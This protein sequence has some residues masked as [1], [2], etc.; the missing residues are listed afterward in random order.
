MRILA[1]YRHYWPDTPPYARI[2]RSILEHLAAGDHETTVYA[3]Q[4]SYNDIRQPPQPWRENVGGVEIRRIRLL[5]ERKQ[6]RLA[7]AI[8][9]MYFSLRAVLHAVVGRR[10]DLVIAN[11]QPPVLMGC[12]LRLV[13]LLTGTPYIYH[14]QDLHP[15]SALLAGDLKRGW[16]YRLL[17]R[18]DS[19]AC[20][21][22]Q[23]VVVLSRDMADALEARGLPIRNVSIINNP[24]LEFDPAARP[25]LPPP[26]DEPVDC[27]RFL[28]AGNIG[29]FQGLE[30]LVAAARLAAGRVPFQ[31]IF[32]GEGVARR[33]LVALAGDLLGR[34]IIFL[35]HQPLETAIAAMRVCDFGVVSLSANVYRFAYPSKSIMYLSAGCPLLALVEPESELAK[36]IERYGLGYVAASRSVAHIAETI[37]K[38]V[39]GRG[40]WVPERRLQIEQV[41]RE[42]YDQKRMLAAWD[43]LIS[44]EPGTSTNDIAPDALAA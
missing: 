4:P 19:A 43:G 29:R 2:L 40:K 9:A 37:V 7:R 21:R 27:A 32:M 38:A 12:A 8:N 23:R 26:L 16:L 30:R 10:Y 5:P 28:F 41:C 3:A 14:C 11:S 17:A 22:A 44:N 31:L 36:T 1:I 18:C 13:C 34:R 39:A 20:R 15:E 42:L 35:P 6:R 33:E 25:A 24:P